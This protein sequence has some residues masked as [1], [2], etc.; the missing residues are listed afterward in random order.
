MIQLTRAYHFSASHRLHVAQFS[1]QQNQ[2]LF[3]K[4][5]NPYGHGHNYRVE[6]S[7]K[8]QVDEATGLVVDLG[9]LDALVTERVVR[10]FDHK[11][12]NSDLA[13]FKT[14]V[15]TTEVLGEVIHER[16]LAVWPASFPKLDKVGIQETKRN[17]FT[18][19]SSK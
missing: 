3:G 11:Y 15:A 12:I 1:D 4:C 2:D 19:P 7:V 16:L 8:G 13:E 14:R 9:A 10:Y 5:N 18:I 17:R 6:I